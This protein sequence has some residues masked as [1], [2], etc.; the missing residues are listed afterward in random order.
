MSNPF[1]PQFMASIQAAQD[2]ARLVDTPQIRALVKTAEEVT[3]LQR[4]FDFPFLRTHLESFTGLNAALS[5][6][7][8]LDQANHAHDIA[9]QL[10]A[11][12][13]RFVTPLQEQLA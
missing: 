12:N 11:Y 4:K 5:T 7:G 8:I 13:D 3:A 9:L 1:D 2:L 10:A 6:V